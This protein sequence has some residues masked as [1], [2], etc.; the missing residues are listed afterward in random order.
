[1]PN[2]ARLSDTISHG[3]SI[4][5]GSP[6]TTVNSLPVARLTDLVDCA[7]HGINSIV[8]ASATVRVN[9]LGVARLG[10]ATACGATISSASPD[11]IAGG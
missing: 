9:G 10:D 7:I 6:D 11:E 5:T 8:S 1:M 4:I 3:G 2:V